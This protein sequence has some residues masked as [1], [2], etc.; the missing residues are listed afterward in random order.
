MLKSTLTAGAVVAATLV[1]AASASAK[2]VEV[3]R[4]DAAAACPDS[5]C[6]A[7]SRTTGYQVKV[8]DERNVFAAPDDGKIVAWTITLGNP[9]AEQT[10]FFDKSLGGAASARI[11]VL[12]LGNK[13]AARTITQSPVQLLQPFFGQ[14]VQFPLSRALNVKK[15]DVVALTVPTWAPALTQLLTDHSSWRA[16]RALDKCNDTGTQTAQMILNTQVQYRCL[17][18]ARL[19][20]SATLITRPVPN[21]APTPTPTPTP[22]AGPAR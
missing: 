21:P 22:T 6:L 5:P 10:A 11:T 18:K 13:L 14:T 4:T 15:G 8:A 7:V 9:T 17:Y 1:C 2:I 20:Y 12:R 3:G 19:T 16:S